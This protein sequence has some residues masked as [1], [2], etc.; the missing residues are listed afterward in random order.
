VVFQFALLTD[1]LKESIMLFVNHVAG[2]VHKAVHGHAGSCNKNI[3]EAWLVVW[4][5]SSATDVGVMLPRGTA[6]QAVTGGTGHT[7][8]DCAVAA[9]I[10]APLLIKAN[11]E[12][13]QVR[14]AAPRGVAHSQPGVAALACSIAEPSGPPARTHCARRLCALLRRTER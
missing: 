5:L 1:C 9:F 7:T 4:P 6:V 10:L 13:A 11:Q 14:A 12:I 2:V 8:A 3:G